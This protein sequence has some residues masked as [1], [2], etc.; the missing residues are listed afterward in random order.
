[1]ERF[2]NERSLLGVWQFSGMDR[3]GSECGAGIGQLPVFILDLGLWIAE[4][5][6]GRVGD[7]RSVAF[8]GDCFRIGNVGFTM[9][10]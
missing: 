1:M 6:T 8:G 9:A 4:F 3:K 10:A 7:R 5:E 2:R